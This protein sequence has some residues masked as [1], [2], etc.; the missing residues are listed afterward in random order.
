MQQ[1]HDKKWFLGTAGRRFREA[2]Q[3][4]HVLPLRLVGSEL[5]ELA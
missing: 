3:E 4:E 2:L 5:K 1:A